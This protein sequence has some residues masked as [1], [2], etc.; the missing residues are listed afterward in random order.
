MGCPHSCSTYKGA[1]APPL[2]ITPVSAPMTPHLF[3]ASKN[4]PS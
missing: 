3:P 4:L 2:C 1:P